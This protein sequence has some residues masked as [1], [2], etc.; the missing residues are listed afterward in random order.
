MELEKAREIANLVYTIEGTEHLKCEL[1][2]MLGES[3]S[4]NLLASVDVK[5]ADSLIAFVD[6]ELKRLKDKLEEM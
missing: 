4:D 5:F 1:E 6:K 2:D 3:Y